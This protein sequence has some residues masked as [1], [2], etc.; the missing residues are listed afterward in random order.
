VEVLQHCQVNP[1]V[2]FGCQKSGGISNSQCRDKLHP[3]KKGSL[4]WVEYSKSMFPLFHGVG[5]P[6]L[7][8]K[9][10]YSFISDISKYLETINFVDVYVVKRMMTEW[11]FKDAFL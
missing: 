11:L 7:Q 9:F 3:H 6:E 1:L 4:L 5:G 2:L 8:L 10:Y